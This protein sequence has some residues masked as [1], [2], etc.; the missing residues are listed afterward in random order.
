MRTRRVSFRWL[1][2]TEEEAGRDS[3]HGT[4]LSRALGPLLFSGFWS[5]VLLAF[6]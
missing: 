3:D 1:V 5:V 2:Q 4:P 6:S